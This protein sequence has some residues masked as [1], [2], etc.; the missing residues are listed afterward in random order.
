M[1]SPV[2]VRAFI[3]Y[4]KYSGTEIRF[5][6][7]CGQCI[8]GEWGGT[9]FHKE[10]TPADLMSETA[11][12]ESDDAARREYWQTRNAALDAGDLTIEEYVQSAAFIDPDS[13]AGDER[14]YHHYAFCPWCG[15]PFEDEWWLRQNTLIENERPVDPFTPAIGG[16]VTPKAL[17]LP[18]EAPVRTVSCRHPVTLR[19]GKECEVCGETV[20]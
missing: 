13:R 12:R 18:G 11:Q 7:A 15:A 1:N 16:V 2:R 5:C 8:S 3:D 9:G 17:D 6:G 4:T 10:Y 19:I 20:K 14:P